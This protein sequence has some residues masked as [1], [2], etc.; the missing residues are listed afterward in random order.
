[1]GLRFFA[2]GKSRGFFTSAEF[3]FPFCFCLCGLSFPC[4]EL[5]RS[6]KRPCGSIAAVHEQ[7]LVLAIWIFVVFQS[8]QTLHQVCY[9]SKDLKKQKAKGAAKM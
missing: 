3:V 9:A 2:L 7:V 5:E 6:L 8:Y 1:M 4:G